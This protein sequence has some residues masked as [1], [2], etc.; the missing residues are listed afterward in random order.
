MDPFFSLMPVMHLVGQDYSSGNIMARLTPV[1]SSYSRQNTRVVSTS[2]GD[3][4]GH[5]LSTPLQLNDLAE[6]LRLK[7]T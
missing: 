1:L 4:P 3:F 6:Y 2:A 7:M 5:S